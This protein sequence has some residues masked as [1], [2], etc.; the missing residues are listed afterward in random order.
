MPHPTIS[1]IIPAYNAEATIARTLQ[2]ILAQTVLPHEII[3]IDDGSRDRTCQIVQTFVPHVKLIKQPNAGPAAARNHGVRVATGEWIAFLDSDDAWVPEK[4]ET[5]AAVL[6][7]GVGL[8][9]TYTLQDRFRYDDDLNFDILWKHNY[10]GTSTV[11]ANK[12][13]F[14]QVGGFVESRDFIGAEDYNLW[15]RLAAT[16]Q[17]IVTVRKELTDYTPAENSLS[18]QI[19]RVIKAE[20]LNMETLAKQYQLPAEKVVSKRA[21]LLDEYAAS[22]FWLRDLPLARQYYRALLNDRPSVRNFGCWMATYLPVKVL[23]LPRRLSRS[24]RSAV[25]VVT[26]GAATR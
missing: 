18:Q 14:E 20:L 9:H 16:G 12:A 26:S 8:S 17:R 15:L 1:V 6:E 5:Q 23:N 11:I 24:Q 25:G 22:L 3:V 13:L 7:P 2:S 19:A 10:I 4:L 21:A